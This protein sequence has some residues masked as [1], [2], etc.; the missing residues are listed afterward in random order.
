MRILVTGGAGFIGSHLAE[1]LVS[2]G[3]D[4]VVLDDFSTGS[5][6]NLAACASRVRIETASVTDRRVVERLMR[7]GFDR[8]AHLAATVGV[9]R[10]ATHPDLTRDVIVEGTRRVLSAA[11]ALR[12]PTLSVSSSEVYGFEPSIPVREEDVLESVDGDAPRL[13]YVHA[14]LAADRFGRDLHRDGSRVLTIRPFN[15]IGPRQSGDGGA[16]LPRFVEQA[17]RGDALLVHGDGRQRR[18]FLDVRDLSRW[19]AD[20]LSMGRWPDAAINIGGTV[21]CSIEELA[22]RVVSRVGARSSVR[23]VEPPA[24]R[25][26]V[27]ILRRVPD[28]TRLRRLIDVAARHSID[29]SIDALAADLAK[30][31]AA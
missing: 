22:R 5:I 6:E 17:L 26:G 27:E 13:S 29:D 16:V 20:L 18:T 1:T 9:E 19:L 10:V 23:H 24:L 30:V 15:V 3:D 25:G 8:V 28:L 12:I 2:R 21:E 11:H 7:S 4:V 14:K 31:A